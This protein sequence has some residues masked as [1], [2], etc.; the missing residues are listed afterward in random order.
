MDLEKY[1]YNF[2]IKWMYFNNFGC[3]FANGQNRVD[4]FITANSIL[5]S[6]I[7]L[8]KHY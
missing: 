1:V 3:S 2:G 7:H 4:V 8:T 5:L 6:N